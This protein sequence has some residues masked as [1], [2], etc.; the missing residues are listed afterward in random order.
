MPL[1]QGHLHSE[2]APPYRNLSCGCKHTSDSIMF[3]QHILC[4]NT[5]TQST[6]AVKKETDSKK[7]GEGNVTV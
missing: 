2:I 6:G 4:K 3:K 1:D 5:D 7:E